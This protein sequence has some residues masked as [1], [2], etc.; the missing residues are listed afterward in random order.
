[1]K[2]PSL[3]HTKKKLT[4]IFTLLVFAIAVL[5]EWVF[6]SAKYYNYSSN[7]KKTFNTVTSAVENKF[8]SLKEFIVNQDVWKR[9]FN[10]WKWT[11]IGL[12]KQTQWDIVNLLIIDRNSRELIFSNVVDNLSIE[13][14]EGVLIESRYWKIEQENWYLIK[15]INIKENN[16]NYDVLFI[17][18]LRYSFLDYLTDLLGFIFITLIFSVL[19]YYTWYKFVS[20][21]LEPVENNLRD[22]QDFIHNAWHE[23]KTPISIIHSNLQLIKETKTFEKE[24]ILEWLTEINRLNHLIESLIELSNINSSEKTEKVDIKEEIK[25]IIKDF[26]VEAEKKEIKIE[27]KQSVEKVLTI[28]KQY[29]YILFSNLIWNA[30]KYSNKWWN[31]SIIL[32]ND[33]LIVKDNWIWINKEDLNK[34]FDRFFMSEK[35][36]NFEWH[37]IWLSLV[38][39]IADI[40]KWKIKVNSEEGKGSEFVIEF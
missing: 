34:I 24:L 3:L 18:N 35:S 16:N 30:I 15:K 13:F 4:V 32:D 38:K 6:F 8:V 17:K 33:K 40:Y 12:W 21:N 10:M 1:M 36:R 9:V 29:F 27:F 31:I 20:K 39:N 26:K 25:I 14:V 5:L 11:H 23:L 19:F 37:G 2:K 7:E 28:N 22:M